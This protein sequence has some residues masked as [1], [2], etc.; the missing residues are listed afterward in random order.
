[1]AVVVGVAVP[2]QA[3]RAASMARVAAMRVVGRKVFL[4]A[5]VYGRADARMGCRHGRLLIGQRPARIRLPSAVTA[6][7]AGR[8]L[9][10]DQDRRGVVNGMLS[11]SRL[12][13][14]H[15]PVLHQLVHA[16]RLRPWPRTAGQTQTNA[17]NRPK[18]TRSWGS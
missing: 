13:I 4:R 11:Q 9:D 16:H 17:H 15:R 1:M 5:W 7:G 8:D 10:G 18:T 14:E 2:A 6:A 3:V 12:I